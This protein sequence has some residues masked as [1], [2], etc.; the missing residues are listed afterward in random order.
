[1]ARY[2]I[3]SKG[4]PGVCKA[5]Q[6]CPFGGA[7]EHY[8]SADQAREAFEAQQGGSFDQPALFDPRDETEFIID[9]VDAERLREGDEYEGEEILSRKVGRKWVTLTTPTRKEVLVPV[10]EKVAV[11]RER[12]TAAAREADNAYQKERMAKKAVEGAQEKLDKALA[13]VTEHIQQYGHAD[14]FR[15]GALIAAQENN[16]VWSSVGRIAENQGIS[17]TEAI[18][19][20]VNQIK[21]GISG[22]G[23]RSG[24]SRS[25]SVV[26]NIMEDAK[27]EA[28]IEFL[29]DHE[30][31]WY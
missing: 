10:G 2:H 19:I 20:K 7:E 9:F 23:F 28:M 27:N 26:S 25:T 1:M 13:D 31:G 21:E 22:Y 4:E 30:R 15:M 3:N 24:L 12:S 16:N 5:Q 18:E 17:Y 29:R 14:S 11:Q 8:D 6:A